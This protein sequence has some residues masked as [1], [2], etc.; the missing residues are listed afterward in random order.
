MSFLLLSELANSISFCLKFFIFLS[1]PYTSTVVTS[2]PPLPLT[3][4]PM[5][6]LYRPWQIP[7]IAKYKQ[8]AFQRK[9]YFHKE[10]QNTFVTMKKLLIVTE[11]LLIVSETSTKQQSSNLKSYWL[12]NLNEKL[13]PTYIGIFYLKYVMQYCDL[14]HNYT[15]VCSNSLNPGINLNNEV[16]TTIKQCSFPDILQVYTVK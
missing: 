5:L 13:Y 7:S 11:T 14:S 10:V 6:F 4:S 15:K 2:F 8:N 1:I 3:Y 9:L 16:I 12:I